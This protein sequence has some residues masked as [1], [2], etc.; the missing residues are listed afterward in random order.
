MSANMIWVCAIL[1]LLLILIPVGR[2]FEHRAKWESGH[3]RRAAECPVCYRKPDLTLCECPK[4][5]LL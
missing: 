3:L 5:T 4:G 2:Y 1:V